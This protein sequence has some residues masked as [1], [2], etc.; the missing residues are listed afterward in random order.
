MSETTTIRISHAP[1]DV[2]SD[3]PKRSSR[4]SVLRVVALLALLAL[5]IG[6]G[7]GIFFRFRRSVSS[8]QAVFGGGGGSSS[9]LSPSISASTS[10]S[11]SASIEHT[12]SPS[13]LPTTSPTTSPST[14]GSASA[15]A[16]PSPAITVCDLYVTDGTAG[17][18]KKV[19]NGTGTPVTVASGYTCPWSITTQNNGDVIVHDYVYQYVGPQETWRLPGGGT[20][21]PVK[22]LTGLTILSIAVDDSTGTVYFVHMNATS[23]NYEVVH[24]VGGTGDPA[25][26]LPPGTFPNPSCVAFDNIRG[27]LWVG[28]YAGNLGKVPSGSTNFVPVA[29]FTAPAGVAVDNLGNVFVLESAGTLWTLTGGAGSPVQLAAAYSFSSPSGLAVDVFGNIFVAEGSTGNV[30]QI[31]GGGMGTPFAMQNGT[32]WTPLG[33]AVAC[34]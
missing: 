15:T 25:M 14:A 11:I 21:T 19:A 16:S 10:P 7:V 24:I 9:S 4:L 33:V 8:A 26:F 32:G 27:D 13:I 12:T 18:V 31:P 5:G 23:I 30:I 20:G 17:A 2:A 1:P 22:L 6:L 28:Q 3:G 34:F 29:P